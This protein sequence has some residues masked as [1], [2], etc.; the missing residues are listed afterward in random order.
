MALSFFVLATVL[1]LGFFG[2]LS[3]EHSPARIKSDIKAARQLFE[4]SAQIVISQ[5]EKG[6]RSE[7]PHLRRQLWE[8]AGVPLRQRSLFLA[9]NSPEVAS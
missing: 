4:T 1:V 3:T 8:A 9:R 5:G 2:M 6:N 7:Y